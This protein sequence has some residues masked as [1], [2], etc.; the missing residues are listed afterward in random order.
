MLTIFNRQTVNATSRAFALSADKKTRD[1]V[2][3]ERVIVPS[4]TFDGAT[5]TV[6]VSA[7]G[8]DFANMSTNVLTEVN[9]EIIYLP[10]ELYIRAVLAG[11]GASTDINLHVV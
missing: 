7:N 11:V 3:S 8:V 10:N 9:A 5:L 6:Q 1:N 2:D 4:G